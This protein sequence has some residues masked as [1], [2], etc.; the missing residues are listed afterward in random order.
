VTAALGAAA[1][2]T[3]LP[4]LLLPAAV[5]LFATVTGKPPQ[6]GDARGLA[7]F[8]GL[9]AALSLLATASPGA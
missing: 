9:I 5:A 1:A 4:P 6:R 3:T 8:L 7:L 2:I